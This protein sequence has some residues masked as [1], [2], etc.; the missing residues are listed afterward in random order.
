MVRPE[1]VLETERLVLR[2]LDMDDVDNVG[3]I[4][5]DPVAM[6]FAPSGVKTDEEIVRWLERAISSYEKHGHGFYAVRLQATGEF[7][8]HVGLLAQ[9]V[10]GCDETE[11]GYWLQRVHW[12]N[13][14]AT[15]AAA[16][17]RDWGFDTLDR[18]R[19]VSII[20]P[21]HTASQ[22]VAKKIGMRLE[23]TT[24]WKNRV[25]QVYAIER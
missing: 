15:E 11:I 6:R 25:H 5:R 12:G 2:H 14:Y 18:P 13:G 7:V 23:Q 24:R 17:C 9:Q 19:L 1:T 21:D 20:R 8:G 4:F 16:A 3:T 22:Q 10:G